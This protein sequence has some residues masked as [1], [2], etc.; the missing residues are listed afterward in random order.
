MT[1]KD[2]HVLLFW[3]QKLNAVFAEKG[4]RVSA[5]E[6]ARYVG[7]STPTAK[8]YLRKLVAERG[9]LVW[10]VDFANGVSGWVYAPNDN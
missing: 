4:R 7:Q 10:Q 3:L 8:R 1:E 5:G 9:A 6:V 2:K